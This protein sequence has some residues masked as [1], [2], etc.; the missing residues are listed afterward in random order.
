M[1]KTPERK[2]ARQTPLD[3]PDRLRIWLASA[4]GAALSI[5]G[6]TA[7]S[8]VVGF[9]R[10]IAFARAVGPTCLGD[11]YLTA[12]T[13]P[14]IV[15][16]V[17]A[18][19][20][21]A[22]LVVPVLAGAVARGDREQAGRT[23]SALL[24]WALLVSVP[25]TILGL[26]VARPLIGLLIGSSA[27][28]CNRHDELVVGTRMLLIF[29][30]Q[31]VFYAICIVLTGILQ[32]HRRFLGPA[33]APL[34]SS[35][36]VIG[37]YVGFGLTSVADDMARV[38]LGAQ[39]LLAIGTTAGVVALSLPLLWPVSRLKLRLRPTLRFPQA[40]GRRVAGLAVAGA[41]TLAAQQ[42]S[43]GVVLRLAHR[44]NT[45][46]LVLYNLA[47]AVFLVPWSVA[48]VPIATSAFPRLAARADDGDDRGY[49]VAAAR[50]LRVVVL[51][52]AAAAAAVVACAVPIARVLALRVPGNADTVALAWTLVAFAPGLLGYGLVAYVGRAFYARTTWRFAAAA[53]CVGWLA[54]IIADFALIPAFSPRW[55]V[56]ALA[57]GNSIGM[58]IAGTL[59]VAGLARATARRALEGLKRTAAASLVGAGAGVGAGLGVATA[60]GA[61]SAVASV[62]V[63]ALVG[64]L[65][66]GV[67]VAIAVAFEPAHDRRQLGAR[68]LGRRPV[69]GGTIG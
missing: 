52:S 9:G 21:L 34:L 22:S 67:A 54:V 20:A 4:V 50:G 6:V 62:F 63:T 36:V 48:A 37:A 53:I 16:E 39:L 13:V 46:T 15:F 45:G 42:I 23:A 14:N 25:V 56:V 31:V 69:G 27:A 19:G 51:A 33:L 2:L 7:L 18:G 10:T 65:A 64:A 41:V 44:G 1:G 26:L 59:L 8:R 55:R 57:L 5:A 47:W 17:V 32:A 30:P 61:R 43:V 28:G 29:M 35:V 24:S 12:N 40:V 11:T 49:A 58:T 68:I 3:A 66:A 38:G 60:I